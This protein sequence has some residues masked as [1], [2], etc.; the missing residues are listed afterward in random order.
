VT[1]ITGLSSD[2]AELERLARDLKRHC[3]VGGTVRDE[4]VELQGEQRQ[5]LQPLL[6]SMG[7]K[8]KVVG[9]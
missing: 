9:G 3:G 8:V 2:P 4:R 7:Y 5:K 1:V 6:A